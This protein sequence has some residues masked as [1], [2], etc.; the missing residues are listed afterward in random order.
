MTDKDR[1]PFDSLASRV[2]TTVSRAP[3]FALCALFIL[4]W[5]IGLPFAGWKNDIYHLLLNSPT[6]AI[7]FLLVAVGANTQARFEKASNLKLN[8]M[9]EAQADLMEAVAD[10]L[11][12]DASS[13]LR[14]DAKQL[15]EASGTEDTVG[16]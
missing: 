1:T 13:N 15:R 5:L 8:A 4:G 16:A 7:T 6:T 3:F 11:Q 2:S 10:T 14:A 12:G 9:A